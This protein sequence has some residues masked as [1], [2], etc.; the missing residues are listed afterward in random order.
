[1]ATLATL[2]GYLLRLQVSEISSRCGLHTV[3]PLYFHTTSQAQKVKTSLSP[4]LIQRKKKKLDR[5]LVKHER[6]S[7]RILKPIDENEVSVPLKRD[8]RAGT[9][10]R[11]KMVYTSEELE[12][13]VLLEK[14]WSRYKMKQHQAEQSACAR[15]RAA[16]EKALE[17]LKE[18]S[19]ELYQ[20]A[21]RCDESLFP[22]TFKGPVNTPPKLGYYAADGNY[23]DKT[24]YFED[25]SGLFDDIDIIEKR[26][27]V[28]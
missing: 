25:D 17:K 16:Q 5:A 12:S 28:R 1:M 10:Q 27:R 3:S 20:A 13:Q 14:D 18:E 19:E 9:R 21:I 11:E 6:R 22:Y 7:E 8:V 4:Q 24:N 26:K 2:R 23:I 15:M